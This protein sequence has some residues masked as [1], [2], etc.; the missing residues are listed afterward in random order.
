MAY[1][2][3]WEAAAGNTVTCVWKVQPWDE[4]VGEE[5]AALRSLG[6][7]GG[8]FGA[9]L[10]PTAPVSCAAV[11][12]FAGPTLAEHAAS[13]PIPFPAAMQVVAAVLRQLSALH[14][15]HLHADIH[16]E[17][18]CVPQPATGSPTWE[19]AQLIDFGSARPLSR[20]GVG[21]AGALR[22]EGPTRGGLWVAQPR[23]QF[24]NPT[25]LD[26]TSDIFS[27]AS[28]LYFLLSGEYPFTP[29]RGQ[30][31]RFKST[32]LH[33]LRRRGAVHHAA[34]SRGMP[35]AVAAWLQRALEPDRARRFPD[36]ASA[37]QALQSCLPSPSQA[38]AAAQ[39]PG[40]RSSSNP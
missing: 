22:Y 38:A 13:G 17:N 11:T 20:P 16:A 15:T 28:L 23:E 1:L 25:T 36:A 7:A 4:R 39:A 37:L 35:A 30:K 32:A 2:G 27:L 9:A 34:T 6:E 14:A 3:Q 31:V 21:G 18:V 40:K 24:D 10:L 26:A 33:T 12:K 29:P 8:F 19:A 5:V